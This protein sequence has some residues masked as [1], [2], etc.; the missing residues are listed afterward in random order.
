MDVLS[1][2]AISVGVLSLILLVVAITKLSALGN[3]VA[4]LAEQ[5][6]GAGM[7]SSDLG[8]QVGDAVG[9]SLEKFV[10]KPEN[11]ASA[12][13]SSVQ[14]ALK[15]ATAQ[16]EDLHQRVL[17]AQSSLLEKWGEYEATLTNEFGTLTKAMEETG[18]TVQSGLAG[19][20]QQASVSFEEGSKKLQAA[21]QSY[22]EQTATSLGDASQK[23]HDA[24][25]NHS[26]KATAASQQLTA[27]LEKIATLEQNIS[28]LL[29]LQQAT[30]KTMQ[31]VAA[32]EE[33][34][35]LVKDLRTHLTA[36]DQALKEI[37][38]PRRIRLVEQ[39][40]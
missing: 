34:K 40:G 7:T 5:I 35:G 36:S 8:K 14:E 26:E 13:T 30:D 18:K 33:F 24:L 16:V 37:A 15:T 12:I 2:V 38:K 9:A 10:P 27:Q 17:D 1:V 6:Q 25:K 11:M 22:A 29:H 23:L 31:S 4:Y 28:N 32:S 3:S 19:T 20:G 21:M 39:G